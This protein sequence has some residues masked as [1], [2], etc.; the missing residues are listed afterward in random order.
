MKTRILWLLFF[1]VQISFAQEKMISG[2]VSDESGPLPGVSVIIKGTTTGTETD[3]DGNYKLKAKV[4]DVLVYSFVGKETVEKRI[5]DSTSTINVTL[6]DDNVLNEIVVTGYSS[7]NKAK[8]A[9]AATVLSAE[10][11]ENKPNPNIL[12]TLTGQVAG[13]DITVNSGQPHAT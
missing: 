5:T 10:K 4:N 7:T 1:F 8:S 9:I 3:F 13:L 12:Q 2:I 6:T 11:L